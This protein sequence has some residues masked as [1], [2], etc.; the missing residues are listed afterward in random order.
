MPNLQ[1]IRT[2]PDTRKQAL[3]QGIANA[4]KAIGGGLRDY[5]KQ[6][7]DKEL[8]GMKLDADNIK[9]EESDWKNVKAVLSNPK[10]SEAMREMA[11]D[12]LAAKG[13]FQEGHRHYAEAMSLIQKAWISPDKIAAVEKQTRRLL[14]PSYKQ[15]PVY[16]FPSSSEQGGL[17]DADFGEGGTQQAGGTRYI[18]GDAVEGGGTIFDRERHKIVLSVASNM[19]EALA[20]DGVIDGIAAE[21][22][23]GV[24][25]KS[26]PD[27]ATALYLKDFPVDTPPKPDGEKVDSQRGGEPDAQRGEALGGALSDASGAQPGALGA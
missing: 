2:R 3:G 14:D 11:T 19:A 8:L 27:A 13:F 23:P 18:G 7:S 22:L 16:F 4:G 20:L 17:T 26:A 15:S 5:A 6:E 24:Y 10:A 25:T 12:F 1:V 21:R 9:Q